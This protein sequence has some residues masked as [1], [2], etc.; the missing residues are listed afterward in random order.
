M[1]LGTDLLS[2]RALRPFQTG[3]IDLLVDV[4]GEKGTEMALWR[5]ALSFYR[6]SKNVV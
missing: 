5:N 1:M 4:L 6:V 2:T 3:D